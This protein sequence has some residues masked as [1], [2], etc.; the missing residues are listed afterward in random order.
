MHG[1]GEERRR[2]GAECNQRCKM[3]KDTVII[4]KTLIHANTN[5]KTQMQLKIIETRDGFFFLANGM[6][7]ILSLSP[8]P[9][10]IDM[11]WTCKNNKGFAVF[12]KENVGLVNFELL[13]IV[14][15]PDMCFIEN[16][17][18]SLLSYNFIW[19]SFSLI[20]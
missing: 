20:K 2:G 14:L 10:P 4:E 8:C 11:D 1:V 13:F 7:W 19:L 3:L 12:M 6:S 15:E 9:P 18:L 5:K 17:S 16:A